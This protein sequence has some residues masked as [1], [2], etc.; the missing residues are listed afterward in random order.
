MV[1]EAVELTAL[2]CKA[3]EKRI[4]TKFRKNLTYPSDFIVN[5]LFALFHKCGAWPGL[6]VSLTD[7]MASYFM[8][9]FFLPYSGAA[10]P[11]VCHVVS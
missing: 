1:L 2:C 7:I 11:E 4:F 6:S 8:S 3:L 9:P 10:S 5:N